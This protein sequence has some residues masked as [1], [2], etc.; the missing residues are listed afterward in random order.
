MQ[1]RFYVF[2]ENWSFLTIEENRTRFPIIAPTDQPRW[3]PEQLFNKSLLLNSC[4]K[5]GF[6]RDA[7]L[8]LRKI[9]ISPLKRQALSRLWQNES[10]L[11][12]KKASHSISEHNI[13]FEGVNVKFWIFRK[14]WGGGRQNID[15]GKI[16]TSLSISPV[17]WTSRSSKIGTT[18][19]N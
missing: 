7:C 18:L 16:L 4:K 2:H 15:F 9:S 11:I 17:G 19:I 10:K 12:F 1:Q 3:D 14:F 8:N 5:L 6:S 13:I